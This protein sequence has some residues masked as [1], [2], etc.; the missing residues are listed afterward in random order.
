M[1]KTFVMTTLLV[2]LIFLMACSGE[3]LPKDKPSTSTN[4]PT[5]NEAT[6]TTNSQDTSAKPSS[7]TSFKAELAIDLESAKNPLNEN[8]RPALDVLEKNLTA[9]VQHDHKLYRSGFVDDQLAD[10]MDFYY[11]EQFQYTFSSIE[12]IEKSAS[13]KKQVHITVLGERLDTTTNSV[14]EVKMMYAIRQNEQGDWDIY[15]ID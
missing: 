9:L 3:S 15:T 6:D 7:N 2:S 10:A 5:Q 12:S 11:G 4:I 8:E 14:E 1:I 13:I